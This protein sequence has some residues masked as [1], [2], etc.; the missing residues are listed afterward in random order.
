LFGRRG[1]RSGPSPDSCDFSFSVSAARKPT[2]LASPPQRS[3]SWRRRWRATRRS[4]LTRTRG[5]ERGSTASRTRN[6]SELYYCLCCGLLPLFFVL[7]NIQKFF[8]NL[9]KCHQC[10]FWGLMD[11]EVKGY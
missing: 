5:S 9:V 7:I 11:E 1:G 10:P 8:S 2:S 6:S 3:S 4:R